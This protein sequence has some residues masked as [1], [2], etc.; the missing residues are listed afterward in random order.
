MKMVYDLHIQAEHLCFLSHGRFSYEIIVADDGSTNKDAMKANMEINTLP[1]CRYIIRGYN[2]G[3]SCI[4]NFMAQQAKNDYLL[5]LDSDLAI[6]DQSFLKSYIESEGNDVVYGGITIGGSHKEY[7]N[8]LRFLYERKAEPEHTLEKRIKNK[9][10][11][12][13]TANFLI[14]RDIMLENLFDE[15]FKNYG[16]EDVLF[17]KKLKQNKIKITHIQNPV[18]FD[19]FE[20]NESFINKSEE[21]LR[22]LFRFSEEL[23]GYTAILSLVGKINKIP[24]LTNIIKLW[25]RLFGRM[26]RAWLTGN[27][28]NLFIFNLYRLGY[29]L[30]I[31]Q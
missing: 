5:F 29:F 16:Y 11:D 25:H 23:N 24:A 9:Y 21:G 3:R 30:N 7:R 22:T 2:T 6:P 4:R 26:E 12:F 1:H 20:T 17:G 31:K 15:R 13:H 28:P 14:R 27:N 8:N 19:N 18:L 10:K